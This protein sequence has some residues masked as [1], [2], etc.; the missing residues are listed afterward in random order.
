MTAAIPIHRQWVIV[1]KNGDVIVDWGNGVFQ[2]IISGEFLIKVDQT[3]S[4][5]IQDDEASWLEKNGSIQGFDR[6]QVYVFSLPELP[7]K[8]ME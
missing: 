5:P 4:H 1:L 7:K 6:A 3:A 2:D 8:S